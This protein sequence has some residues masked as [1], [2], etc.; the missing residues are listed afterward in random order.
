VDFEQINQSKYLYFRPDS[1]LLCI[2][3]CGE[4][5]HFDMR[6]HE[7]NMFALLRNAFFKDSDSETISKLHDYIIG[8]RETRP[9]LRN[10]RV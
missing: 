3:E 10:W 7:E 9:F 5:Q 2:S 6:R 1:C 4:K 8:L